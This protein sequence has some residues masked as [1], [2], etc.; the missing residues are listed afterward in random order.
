M[1]LL[2]FNAHILL[3]NLSYLF[4]K[5]FTEGASTTSC[6]KLFQELNTFWEKKNLKRCVNTL[7][8]SQ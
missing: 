3:L 6:G 4:L 2:A 8:D 5:E 1:K 7:T